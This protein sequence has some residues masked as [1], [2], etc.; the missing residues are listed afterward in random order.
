[1]YTD[2]EEMKKRDNPHQGREQMSGG[3]TVIQSHFIIL[4]TGTDSLLN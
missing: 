1:M 4:N 3:I 2:T